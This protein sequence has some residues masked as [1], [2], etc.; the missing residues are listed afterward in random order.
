MYGWLYST[1]K[2]CVI[3]QN[4]NAAFYGE[5]SRFGQLVHFHYQG[6]RVSRRPYTIHGVLFISAFHRVGRLYRGLVPPLLLEAPK[7]AV[8]LLVYLNQKHPQRLTDVY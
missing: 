4:T 5:E 7:R 8:K 1:V 6:G 3:G 2:P